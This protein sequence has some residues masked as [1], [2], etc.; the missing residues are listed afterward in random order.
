[1][2]L[3]GFWW[4]SFFERRKKK[5]ERK[6]ESE[7]D[8]TIYRC[9][10]QGSSQAG[11]TA[12]FLA[13]EMLYTLR[14]RVAVAC[15]PER[16]H[17]ELELASSSLT[18]CRSCRFSSSKAPRKASGKSNP[19]EEALLGVLLASSAMGTSFLLMNLGKQALIRLH[20]LSR[21]ALHT[22]SER[23]RVL[24]ASTCVGTPQRSHPYLV[25]PALPLS[26]H[27]TEDG[28]HI[29]SQAQQR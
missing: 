28:Q 9:P 26:P 25:A 17:V 3:P 5:K 19:T 7:S 18:Y 13:A 6:K 2:P 29:S 1:M 27:A 10:W 22:P 24:C 21:G 15:L 8:I 4:S 11:N 20:S 23:P 12:E 14:L 16:R